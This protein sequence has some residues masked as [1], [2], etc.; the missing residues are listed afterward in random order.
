[1]FYDLTNGQKIEV[2]EIVE[3]FEVIESRVIQNVRALWNHI[4]ENTVVDYPVGLNRHLDK[5][6]DGKFTPMPPARCL[7]RVKESTG[8]G[9]MLGWTL[10]SIGYV[11]PGAYDESP[12]FIHE[13]TFKVALVQPLSIKLSG[14]PFSASRYRKPVIV[15][16]WTPWQER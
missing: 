8:K 6:H 10:R 2:G 5:R 9:M 3:Y 1:M 11:N 14:K 16:A 12:S 7:F 4:V 13:K 15:T